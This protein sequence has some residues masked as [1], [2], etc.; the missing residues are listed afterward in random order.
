LGIFKE[1]L[2][3]RKR[4]P[5]LPAF[6]TMSSQD[7]SKSTN[8]P[9]LVSRPFISDIQIQRRVAQ[10]AGEIVR[11]LSGSSLTVVAIL[12][13]SFIFAADLTR[14]LSNLGLTPAVDF[15]RAA[16]YGDKDRSSGEVKILWDVTMPLEGRNV[17]LIDDIIDTG[18]TMSCLY[19]YLLERKPRLLRTCCLLD[20]SSRREVKFNPDYIGFV[21]PDFFV[22]GYGLD[23]ADSQ[24]CLPYIT[25][26]QNDD[27]DDANANADADA[28]ADANA[29]ADAD[30]NADARVLGLILE[31]WILS[32]KPKAQSLKPTA[33]SLQPKAYSPKPTAQSL[34]P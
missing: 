19:S 1:S 13:G 32:L 15:I 17:L 5:A 6:I 21:I 18:R 27:D 11:D 23:F 9:L 20:K 10:L 29:N 24:R 28:N 26:R 7:K 31:P 25:E 12:K 34:K 8:T 33:Q 2:P 30:A 22:V 3:S 16:S 14:R 4:G